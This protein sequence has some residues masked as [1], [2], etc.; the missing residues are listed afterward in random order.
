MYHNGDVPAPIVRPP[1]TA[2]VFLDG[3][4]EHVRGTRCEFAVVVQKPS[5]GVIGNP[6]GWNPRQVRLYRLA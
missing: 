5:P 4:F 2:A 3:G 1:T 6:A